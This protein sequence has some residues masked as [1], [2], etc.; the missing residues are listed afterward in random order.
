MTLIGAVL[1]V[2]SSRLGGSAAEEV[3]AVGEAILQSVDVR[4]DEVNLH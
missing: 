3:E 2:W 1:R 4:I